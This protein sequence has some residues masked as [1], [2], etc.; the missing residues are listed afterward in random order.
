LTGARN[1]VPSKNN[2]EARRCASTDDWWAL[3]V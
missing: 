2:V 3:R 1:S